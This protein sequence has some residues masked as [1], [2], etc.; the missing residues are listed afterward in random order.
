MNSSTGEITEEEAA[1]ASSSSVSNILLPVQ[2][3]SSILTDWQIH[4]VP[5]QMRRKDQ[6]SYLYDPMMVS[7]GPYHHGKPHLRQAEEFKPQVLDLLFSETG[8][9]KDFFMRMILKWIDH[10]RSCYVGISRDVYDDVKLAEMMLADASLI[11]Y[12]LD[13]QGRKL[14]IES[15]VLISHK[16][17]GLTGMELIMRDLYVLEN[18][19]PY[20]IVQFLGN[21]RHRRDHGPIT[22]PLVQPLHLLAIDRAVLV[23]WKQENHEVRS[24]SKLRWRYSREKGSITD[25]NLEK[26]SR[27][28]RSVMDLK[29]KGIRFRPSSKVLTDIRFESYYFHGKLQLPTCHLTEDFKYKCSNMIAFEL[30]P[31]IFFDF[32]VTS[33]VNFMKSL[34]DSPNDVKELREKGIFTTTLSNKEVVQMF[35]EMDTYGLEQKD[36]FIEPMDRSCFVCCRFGSLSLFSSELLLNTSSK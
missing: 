29:A 14:D 15:F 2:T 27:P 3:S 11:L 9:D 10:I 25:D 19:I 33:Y 36:A 28:F 8:G 23:G 30:S 22:S 5:Q 21:F 32:G 1:G 31:G 7:Y 34:I 24:K 4:R 35:E 18:Q 6:T 16:A 26:L 13:V 17:L 12:V 20:W